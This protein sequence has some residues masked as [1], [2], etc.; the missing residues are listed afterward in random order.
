MILTFSI[1]FGQKTN[2]IKLHYGCIKGS[3]IPSEDLVGTGYSEAF[4]A[5][6]IGI[7]YNKKIS[8]IFR[9]E[10]GI[11]YFSSEINIESAPLPQV[12]LFKDK[13]K[14]VS[15]PISLITEFW[16]YFF[17]NGGVL[18]DFQ[19]KSTKYLDSQS[20]VGF[21]LGLGV[22][23]EYKEF[24]FYINPEIRRHRLIGFK[25]EKYPEFLLNSAIQIGIGYSF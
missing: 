6:E 14:L 10:T 25:N 24:V 7:T 19:A 12:Y 1:S 8:K 20:G 17:V 16:K 2:Q 5:N 11:N 21:M 23:Y 22:K 15:I 4:K 3:Y 13:L 9:I 18:I